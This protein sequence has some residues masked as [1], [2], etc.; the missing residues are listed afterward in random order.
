MSYIRITGRPKIERDT[1]GL[2]KITRT[3]VVQGDAVTE[4]T[5]EAEVFLPFGTMDVE[6]HDTITQDLQNGGLTNN[7][8]TG[9]Y[10]VQQGITPGQNINEA[11]LTRVYQELDASN[12]PVQVG[13]DE[14]SL[15]G[16]DRLQV[17]RTFIVKNPYA[18]HYAKGRVGVE[19]IDFPN[20]TTLDPAATTTCTLG[21]VQSKATE[22]YTEF[23]EGWY[24]DGVL[25]ESI[26]YKYGQKPNH[27]LEIR[28]VRGIAKPSLPPSSEGPADGSGEPWF[29]VESRE[30]PGNADY[31]QI[32]KTVYTVIFAKGKGLISESSEVKGRAPNTVTLTTIKYLT[33]EGGTV[34]ASA[35]PSF[36]RQT[37]TGVE[38]QSG[39]ELHT[40][41]GVVLDNAVGIVDISVDHKHGEAPDHKL[42]MV[43][44][45]SYGVAPT[46]GDV[47]TYLYPSGDPHAGL[48]DFV[49]ISEKEDTKGDF[50][51]YTNTFAR[52]AGTI[53]ESTRKVGLTEVTETVSIQAAGTASGTALGASELTRKVDQKDGYEI[54]TVTSTT[55]LSGI[56]D[57]RTETKLNG[58]LTIVN[59]TQLGSV[60][61]AANTPGGYA[62]ISE[63][64]HNYDIYPAITKVFAEGAGEISRTTKKVGLTTVT[65][66]V[67]LYDESASISPT[68]GTDELSKR[69]EEKDGYKIVHLSSTSGES[70]IVDQ[71]ED[72]KNNGALNIKTITQIGTWDAANNPADYVEISTRDHSYSTYEAVTKVFAKGAGEIS[73]AKRKEGQTTITDTVTLYDQSASVTSDLGADELSRR[74]ED[75]DGYKIVHVS[76]TAGETGI[77]DEKEDTKNNGSLTIKTITQIGVWD[78]DNSPADYVEIST[79]DHTYKTYAAVTKVFAKG[80]GTVLTATRDEPL[81]EI[82]SFVKLGSVSSPPVPPVDAINIKTSEEDGYKKVTYDVKTP[83]NPE[84]QDKFISYQPGFQIDTTKE[85]NDAD[86]DDGNFGGSKKY[87]DKT[88]FIGEKREA[89]LRTTFDKKTS[90]SGG[91]KTTTELTTHLSNPGAPTEGS[92]DEVGEGVFKKV[93]ISREDAGYTDRSIGYSG[94]M[95]TTRE[96]VVEDTNTLGPDEEGTAEQVSENL[97]RITTVDRDSAGFTD[98]NKR[99]SGGLKTRSETTVGADDSEPS[100]GSVEIVGDS[101]YRKTDVTFEAGTLDEIRYSRAGPYARRKDLVE[102]E[103]NPTMSV[104]SGEY[105]K[106][107]QLAPEIHRKTTTTFEDDF[108]AGVDPVILDEDTTYRTGLVFYR[109]KTLRAEPTTTTAANSTSGGA[110]GDWTVIKQGESENQYGQKEYDFTFVKVSNDSHTKYES[111]QFQ[112]PGCF[113]VYSDTGVTRIDPVTRPVAMEIYTEYST[114]STTQT[115]ATPPSAGI[116]WVVVY[117]SNDENYEFNQSGSNMVWY[118]HDVTDI[119]LIDEFRGESVESSTY[120]FT[121]PAAPTGPGIGDILDFSSRVVF[122]SGAFIC[123]ENTTVRLNETFSWT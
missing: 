119:S 45:V 6:Y 65:E 46:A 31:G 100:L 102:I 58:A 77:V 54:L 8:V 101:T 7:E 57:E 43:R 52:G 64:N 116:D 50:D 22:V 3:Y 106:W 38:E 11:I 9:A 34:P 40:I 82:E 96:T 76:S 122:Q 120:S 62:E 60:W 78:T 107:D 61:D 117:S 121:P 37:F 95:K 113:H 104:S 89:T 30:G 1:N 108:P 25:S 110:A 53:A 99:E 55:A 39:Y 79:R 21:S 105:V 86:W 81:F 66:T 24:E 68:L 35:I 14:V 112:V 114:V 4:G 32:G 44:A 72:T 111:R 118:K 70:G 42:E 2:R 49:L 17:K 85:L 26:D 12:E 92:L 103:E 80:D 28:T 87:I 71:K 29:E 90:Y 74:V 94:G 16:A 47:E 20:P 93:T 5:V 23:V 73:S 18:E 69:I 36:T 13:K 84:T 88:N 123:Y 48:G 91:V 83:H 109:V 33:G 63:R 115:I 75:K 59:K 27:K 67:T 19:T 10:L 56:V 51:V 15:T 41:R 98:V 97:Y